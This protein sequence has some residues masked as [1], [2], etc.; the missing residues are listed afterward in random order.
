[1]VDDSTLL[2]K[3]QPQLTEPYFTLTVPSFGVTATAA[4]AS[5]AQF[6]DDSVCSFLS[7]DNDEYLDYNFCPENFSND[8]FET[9]LSEMTDLLLD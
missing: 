2:I 3:K 6:Y 1:M 5:N 4:A 9:F 7:Q 8:R